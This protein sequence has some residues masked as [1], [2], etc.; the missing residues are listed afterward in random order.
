MILK[1]LRGKES[2]ALYLEP[3]DIVYVSLKMIA[4]TNQWIDHP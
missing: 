1:M 2:R 3:R 4:D